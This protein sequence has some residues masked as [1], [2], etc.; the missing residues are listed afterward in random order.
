MFSANIFSTQKV[1]TNHL[2]DV[3]FDTSCKL[4][5]QT[6]KEVRAEKKEKKKTEAKKKAN[7]SWNS[8]GQNRCHIKLQ[9]N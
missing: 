8:R 9:I 7:D 3:I 2:S 4:P 1:R 5:N 6:G